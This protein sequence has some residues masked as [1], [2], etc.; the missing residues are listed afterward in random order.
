[1]EHGRAVPTIQT[2]ERISDAL[3]VPVY[4]LLYNGDERAEA[5][6]TS[7]KIATNG[8]ARRSRKNAV[9]LLR[10]LRGQLS[11]MREDDQ[12]LLLFIARKMAGRAARRPGIGG[13]DNGRE[14]DERMIPRRRE[15][16]S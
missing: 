3:D 14:L 8:N 16:D 2:L 1:L 6:R 15:G 9:R 5:A 13:Q 11:R 7:R 10:E 4:R 12:Y